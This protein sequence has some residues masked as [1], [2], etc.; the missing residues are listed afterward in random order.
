MREAF[1]AELAGL[2]RRLEEELEHASGLLGAVAEAIPAP[3]VA[4]VKEITEDALRL[5]QAGRTV[6]AELVIV[7]ARQAPVAGDL[8]L[9]L[10]LVEL[11]HHSVLIANQFKLICEQLAYLRPVGAA[12]SPTAGNLAAMAHLAGSQLLHAVGAFRARD[13][14]LARQIDV[15][16]DELD[17]LNRQVFEA[18][19]AL[20]QI[21]QRERALRHVLIARSLERIGDNAVDIAEQATFLVTAQ[22]RQFT[23]ASK[24]RRRSL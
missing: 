22:Q 20:D 24:P 6:D 3:G 14:A 17:Q 7:T 19:V 2:E 16:D 9:V 8:R 10:G 1:A 15:E 5:R 4:K 11:A 13:L 12:G 18:T 21:G 23:D